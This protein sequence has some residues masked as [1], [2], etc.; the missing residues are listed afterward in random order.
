MTELFELSATNSP[1][2]DL[3]KCLQDSSEPLDVKQ[4]VKQNPEL[5]Q[6]EFDLEAE[7]EQ[8][9]RAGTL[10]RYPPKSKKGQSRYWNRDPQSLVRDAVFELIR[11][12]REPLAAKDIK[13]KLK[14]PISVT[15]EQITKLADSTVESGQLYQVS[16]K[17][18]SSGIRYWDRKPEDIIE[19]LL[20]QFTKSADEPV[21]LNDVKKG[22]LLPFKLSDDELRAVLDVAVQQ[23]E[24]NHI[25]A[26]SAKNG[27]RYWSQDE[28]EFARRTIRGT[29]EQKGTQ[30]AASLKKTIGWL[31][32][33]QANTLLK[34]LAESRGI[35]VQPPVGSSKTVSFG[36][37]P[38][39][40]GPYLKDVGKRLTAVVEK[41]RGADVADVEL[42]RAIVEVIESS[43]VSL[44]GLQARVPVTSEPP[45]STNVDLVVLM[46]KLEP[47]AERGALVT[48]RVLRQAANISKTA[49]DQLAL[50]LAREGRIVLHEHDF[51][52]S[53]SESDRDLL[54]SDGQGSYF[55]GMALRPR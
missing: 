26:K 20:L 19:P 21:G 3:L 24:L 36:A 5:K 44:S 27:P 10:Y 11:E 54:I 23:G 49:F 46:K 7:L 43:G 40:P 42:R 33:D 29:L 25:P 45:K 32:S 12:S 51:P 6:K 47:A 13:K 9:T 1:G 15:E 39:V 55:V 4:L 48:A 50:A 8:L 2:E 52:S 37:R 31:T 17:T 28:V 35:F 38:P 34:Q 30:T 53:L 16:P 22:V 14:L 18:K 41:L